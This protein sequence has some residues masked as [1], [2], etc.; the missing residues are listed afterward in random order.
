MSELLTLIDQSNCFM[1]AELILYDIVLHRRDTQG[2]R[3]ISD[4]KLLYVRL[5]LYVK[6]SIK[7]IVTIA[8]FLHIFLRHI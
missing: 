8:F 7:F 2:L 4:I 1:Q 6:I 5:S 3:N